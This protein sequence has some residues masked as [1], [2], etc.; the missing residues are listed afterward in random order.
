MVVSK[1]PSRL[2]AAAWRRRLSRRPARARSSPR[3]SSGPAASRARRQAVSGRPDHGRGRRPTPGRSRRGSGGRGWRAPRP[4]RRAAAGRPREPAVGEADHAAGGGEPG[5]Q[6]VDRAV[7][8]RRAARARRAGSIRSARVIGPAARMSIA[9]SRIARATPRFS[10]LDHQGLEAPPV[11]RAREGVDPGEVVGR[12][13]VGRTA[14][15][16]GA[17]ERCGVDLLAGDAATR[18]RIAS[19]AART[20]WAC[21][22]TTARTAAAGSRP[23]TPATGAARRDGGAGGARRDRR[24]RSAPADRMRGS[25]VFLRTAAPQ[26]VTVLSIV[27]RRQLLLTGQLRRRDPRHRPAAT[28]HEEL[29]AARRAL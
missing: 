18:E 13:Q 8:E 17:D 26:D 29:L 12:D 21:T 10:A 22:P 1:A 7:A 6:D 9:G 5:H 25:R 23:P 2:A 28:G 24:R 20:S 4:R 27:H 11:A 16:P 14:D 19:P 3:G 15:G